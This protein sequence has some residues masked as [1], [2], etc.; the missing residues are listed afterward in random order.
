[1]ENTLHNR[2]SLYNRKDSPYVYVQYWDEELLCY[3]PGR[4]TG[5]T[6][7]RDAARIAQNWLANYGG[8]PPKNEKST[9]ITQDKTIVV[10]TRFLQSHG[11]LESGQHVSI[12]EILSKT[13]LI[14][15]GKDIGAVLDKAIC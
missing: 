2:Y 15:S 8:L 10:L 4:S 13:S 1:M 9:T 7:K 12:D 14:M 11:V 6:N 3:K 5:K